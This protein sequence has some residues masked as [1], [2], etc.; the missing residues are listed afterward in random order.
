MCAWS[1]SMPCACWGRAPRH[2]PRGRS[3]CPRPWHATSRTRRAHRARHAGDLV[4]PLAQQ[5][6]LEL[7]DLRRIPLRDMVMEMVL[8]LLLQLLQ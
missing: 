7:L 4:Q 8:L 3:L 6:R 5:D 2:T 1:L